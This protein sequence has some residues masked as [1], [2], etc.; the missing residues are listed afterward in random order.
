MKGQRNRLNGKMIKNKLLLVFEEFERSIAEGKWR[1]LKGIHSSKRR[2]EM[3][4]D[5][6]YI[7]IGG[8]GFEWKRLAA[9]GRRR[10]P[11]VFIRTRKDIWLVWRGGYKWAEKCLAFTNEEDGG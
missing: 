9:A 10:K 4:D 6:E 5:D 11:M 7:M 3:D 2:R 1:G 8:I